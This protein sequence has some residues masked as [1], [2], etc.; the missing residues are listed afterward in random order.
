M[1]KSAIRNFAI[2]AR[3]L[4]NE[5]VKDKSAQYGITEKEIKE[6]ELF[7]DGFRVGG[8]TYNK[9]T[10]SQYRHLKKEIENRGFNNVIEEVAYTW[11]N[12]IIAL[13][14]MEINGYMPFNIHTKVLAGV[15]GKNEPEVI[16]ASKDLGIVSP[17]V[18]YSH[19]DKGDIEGLYKIILINLCNKLSNIM[20]DMF[21][22]ISDYTELLLPDHLYTEGG[23]INLLVNG[24]DEEDFKNQ[25]EIIG[26][27]YQF[28]I[29]EK[30]AQVD[31]AV[32]KG[33]NVSKD[34]LPAKTQL[35]TPNWIVKYL[36]ENSLG[37][38]WL[39]KGDENSLLKDDWKYYLGTELIIDESKMSPEEIRIIDP[40]CGSG[41]ILVYAFDILY[42]IYASCGYAES[43]I[44]K[45]ILEKNLYGIDVDKRAAQLAYFAVIM[46]ARSKNRRL[47]RKEEPINVNI[48]A[49]IESN[50]II[51]MKRS[52]ESQLKFDDQNKLIADYLVE[53][54]KD[55]REYGSILKVKSMD[56]N[57]LLDYIKRIGYVQQGQMDIFDTAFID[58]VLKDMP[59]II[60]QAKIMSQKYDVVVTNPPYLGKGMSP[61]LSQ[62][63]K[64]NYP[65]SKSD[66]FAV[67]MEIPLLKSDA[68]LAMINQHSW[69][70]LSS[71]EKLRRK[72]VQEK[73]IAS[74]L[75]LG[76][77]AFEEIG[78][79]VVQS[80]AFVLKNRSLPGFIGE[81]V[82][83]VDFGTAAEKEKGALHAIEDKKCG[84][85]FSRNTENFEKIPG[86]P[87]A[88][89]VS[90][91]FSR[92]Y[93]NKM[94][95][96]DV[97]QIKQ[98]LATGNNN[99]HLKIWYEIK[100][101]EI[102][103]GF[104]NINSF[105][106]SKNKYAPYNKGGDFRKWYGNGE[107]VIK[108]DE[109]NYNILLT[110][111]NHL[112]SRDYYFKD[113]ITWTLV[114]TRSSF[115]ARISN[116]GYVFDVGGSSG[117]SEHNLNSFLGFLC[118]KVAYR[119]LEVLNPTI[120]V[121]V[122]NL[123]N[124]P[125]NEKIISDVRID[126]LVSKNITISKSDW[127]DFETSWDF[128]VHP[129]VRYKASR[130]EEAFENWA[131]VAEE[132]FN[133]LK[134][135]EEELN[136]IFIEIY[137]LQGEL[138]PDVAEEDVT[139]R[140]AELDRDIRSLISYAVGCMFGRYSLDRE[141]LVFAGG[142]FDK[143]AY[144]IF[145]PDEDNIIPVTDQ[146]F[147]ENDLVSRFIEFIEKVYGEE[148]L[149]ENLD[150]I[151][152]AL[153]PT[154]N[155]TARHIIREYFFNDFFK[156]HC[157]IYKK[158]PIYWQFDTGRDGAMK[159]LVYL[160]RMDEY[161]P[162]RIRTDYLHPLM[163]AYEGEI[164]R[165]EQIPEDTLTTA[166][167]A[168]YRKQREDFQKKTTEIMKYD[169]II[170]HVAN[171]RIK[172]DLDDGVKVNYAKYQ[173]VKIKE[174]GKSSV[175]ANLLTKI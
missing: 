22:E 14:F 41:H 152:R 81:Y 156:D 33:K 42:D 106:N 75:H 143:E 111:G 159:A 120:N 113:G 155:K 138:T 171:Q 151:A 134:V 64:D 166:E 100:F 8:R 142:K 12:R 126:R 153:K 105:H 104:K 53:T 65:D 63:V 90:E 87:I 73:T 17:Q 59:D 36:V 107:Y 135:N 136:R 5:Q 2:A 19:F 69:M 56:Y 162:A 103:F 60:R 74:M 21:E 150:F 92:N 72:V 32:A 78:G 140:R 137:G 154:S 68:Y 11:F 129:L 86:M 43:D 169:P 40:A 34:D 39:E 117:F 58:R 9:T 172:S 88:Y 161:T 25:V 123:K 61:L 116:Q 6:I 1:D 139:V 125:Y 115:G 13:R 118:S 141:G 45:F 82:R 3:T 164:K 15:D 110:V 97:M 163:R 27:L 132:R 62:Y 170:A 51:S 124:L 102:G 174:N 47:F 98:G 146:D 67:F 71:Y 79:E 46:K 145:I 16:H 37:R 147:F 148:Y 31:E 83:L 96:S 114:S 76:P 30:K 70:F 112:P 119:Y 168:F 48:C 109:K 66:L 54:F 130:I 131:A 85:R 20:P 167:K 52:L 108:F 173:N 18:Y 94:M 160:H 157:K 49:I 77:R 4:L 122:G 7:G 93:N 127:D 101:N 55:A 29:S 35:F 144:N 28:Y 57:G 44:P 23:I 95:L 121:Q 89:W 149:E 165:I 175:T 80:T 84:F 24:I 50:S 91:N 128:K 10:L 158:R 99:Y 133:Q 26:W 38:L